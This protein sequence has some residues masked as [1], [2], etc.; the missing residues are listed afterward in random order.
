[1]KRD[2]IAN[3]G[4]AV[5]EMPRKITRPDRSVAQE[6]DGVLVANRTLYLLVAKHKMTLDH[7]NKA[8][9][10]I[11]SKSKEFVKKSLGIST[12]FKVSCAV[13]C[14]QRIYAE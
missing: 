13:Q 2:L 14:F 9:D 7:L 10:D 8:A 1:M 3:L 6:W 12:R 5:V 11:N 4:D